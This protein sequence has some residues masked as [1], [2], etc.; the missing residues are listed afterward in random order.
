MGANTIVINNGMIKFLRQYSSNEY[1]DG[2]IVLNTY[3]GVL[4]MYCVIG[5]LSLGAMNGVHIS[6]LYVDGIRIDAYIQS[7]IPASSS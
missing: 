4:E 7:F 3:S 6:N 1:E 2:R 5:A